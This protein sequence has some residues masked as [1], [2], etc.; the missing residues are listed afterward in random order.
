MSA[1]YSGLS[2]SHRARARELGL[3]A[4]QKTLNHKGEVHY[5]Q[6]P[7]RWEGIDEGLKGWK[8][9]FPKHADCS[10]F[11][12][13]VLWNGLDHYD[14]HDIVNGQKWKAGYTGTLAEH[15]KRIHGARKPLDLV[16]YGYGWPYEHVAVVAHD[17]RFVYSHGSEAGPFYLPIDYRPDRAQVRRYI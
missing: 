2:R 5:T 9:Q 6:G 10:A 15:G 11:A 12:T 3:I 14:M 16:L 7:Q 17:T 8:G 4:C 13:W 1:T